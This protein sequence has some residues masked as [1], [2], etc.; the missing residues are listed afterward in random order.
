M[1]VSSDRHTKALIL[2]LISTY[3]TYC[4]DSCSYYFFRIPFLITH[5]HLVYDSPILLSLIAP[6]P[7]PFFTLF[8]VRYYLH[9][10]YPPPLTSFTTFIDSCIYITYC[11]DVCNYYLSKLQLLTLTAC[12]FTLNSLTLLI[13]ILN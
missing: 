4:T 13:F 11:T 12:T 1:H 6:K 9:A 3:I 7:S 2:F 5:L 8:L 10:S